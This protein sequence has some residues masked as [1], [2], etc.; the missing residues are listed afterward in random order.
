VL[1]RYDFMFLYI[2]LAL[3][4]SLLY[5]LSV[6][7]FVL[8]SWWNKRIYYST[9]VSYG[10][11]FVICLSSKVGS[12]VETAE[13]IQLVWAWGFVPPILRSVKK[14][15]QVSP[16]SKLLLRHIDRRKK[17]YSLSVINWTVDNTFELRRSTEFIAGNR[18]ALSTAWSR[19][20]GQWAT[21]DTCSI[22]PTMFLTSRR[23][24]L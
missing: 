23:S 18:Q 13:W 20:A 1:V 21:A 24:A 5:F 7:D 19:R 9:D 11:V 6:I 17:V 22:G 14:Q 4:L 16:K 12:S 10:T 2:P 15:I 3:V 8:P